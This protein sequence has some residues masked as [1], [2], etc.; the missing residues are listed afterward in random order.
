[1]TLW[2]CEVFHRVQSEFL[3]ETCRNQEFNYALST[4]QLNF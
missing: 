1:M 3:D 2:I 4:F